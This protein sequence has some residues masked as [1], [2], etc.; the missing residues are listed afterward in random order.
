MSDD[1]QMDGVE[2]ADSTN[3]IFTQIKLVVCFSI[4][5]TPH[6]GFHEMM[7]DERACRTPW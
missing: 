4:I 7:T 5:S 3:Q 1:E 6:Q 2:E